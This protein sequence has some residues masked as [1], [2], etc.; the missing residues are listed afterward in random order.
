MIDPSLADELRPEATKR[1]MDW[2]EGNHYANWRPY[3][4][5]HVRAVWHTLTD[6]QKVAIACDA[7]ARAREDEEAAELD[8]C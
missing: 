6:D 1:R 7:K 8:G 3:V 5:P 2:N 4:G